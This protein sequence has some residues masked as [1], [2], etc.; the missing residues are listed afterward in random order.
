[1][2][3][4]VA[5]ARNCSQNPDRRPLLMQQQHKSSVKGLKCLEDLGRLSINVTSESPVKLKC[6]ERFG[7]LR[8]SSLHSVCGEVRHLRGKVVQL[9]NME[10]AFKA[11]LQ[12]ADGLVHHIE[13]KHLQRIRELE[14]SLEHSTEPSVYISGQGSL[15]SLEAKIRGSSFP[16]SLLDY[17]LFLELFLEL[18][19]DHF[20]NYF[21]KLFPKLFFEIIF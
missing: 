10:A 9:E 18:F 14:E 5:S 12:Q 15:E 6:F 2:D 3:E 11:T 7:W 17:F 21:W 20:L 4:S 8:F 1:M 13:E 16:F 19:L